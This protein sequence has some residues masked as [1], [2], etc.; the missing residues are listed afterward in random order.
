MLVF[1]HIILLTLVFHLVSLLRSSRFP[2][3]KSLYGP[4]FILI[5]RPLERRIRTCPISLGPSFLGSGLLGA[6]Y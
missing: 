1:S 2:N 6:F 3:Y 4:L 5:Q